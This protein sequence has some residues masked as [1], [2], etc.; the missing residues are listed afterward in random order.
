MMLGKRKDDWM[1]SEYRRLVAEKDW[2]TAM[3]NRDLIASGNW[4][5]DYPS[6][7]KE[8]DQEL[9]KIRKQSLILCHLDEIKNH[10]QN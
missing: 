6:W 10:P 4:T 3:A 9:D 2:I 8:I 5:T 7:H 1:I